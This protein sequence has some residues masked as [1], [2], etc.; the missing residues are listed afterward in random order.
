V[1][2]VA[3]SVAGVVEV[4]VESSSAIAVVEGAT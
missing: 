4:V 2:S 3:G 1:S